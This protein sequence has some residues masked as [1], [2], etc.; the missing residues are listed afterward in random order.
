MLTGNAPST[1]TRVISR[2]P[3][4]A[5]G[6]SQG[7]EIRA[8]D[9]FRISKL[10]GVEP[11][12][13]MSYLAVNLEITNLFKDRPFQIPTIKSHF[14]LTV[15]DI[16]SCPASM[17]TWLA[18]T[19]LTVPGDFSVEIPKGESKAGV[20][21]FLV[22]EAEP[23]A[24][25][26]SFYDTAYGHILLPL[27]GSPKGV[28]IPIEQLPTTAPAKLS[29]T[30]TITITGCSDVTRM[31]S[32]PAP[33]GMVY[34]VVEGQIASNVQALLDLNPGERLFLDI[35][36]GSGTF[37]LP[38]SPITDT[39]PMG[40]LSPKMLAPGS[41]NTFRWVFEVPEPLKDAKAEIYGDISGGAIR[42]PVKDGQTYP[43]AQ[44]LGTYEG[45]WISLT[46]NEM[47]LMS[48]NAYSE[49]ARS[50][51]TTAEQKAE[52]ERLAE[53]E[54]AAREERGEE[55]K[56]EPPPAL[57]TVN[58]DGRFYVVAD[59]T[60]SDKPDGYGT[61]DIRSTV[62]FVSGGVPLGKTAYDP[63]ENPSAGLGGFTSQSL[64]TGPDG[65]TDQLALG[66][67]SAFAV[68]DG[69]SRRGLM[70]FALEGTD[71][72]LSSHY[73][74]DLRL[75]LPTSNYTGAALMRPKARPESE[76]NAFA[77]ALDSEIRRVVEAW[78]A[79]HPKEAAAAQTAVSAPFA[80]TFA[81]GT[82]EIA[83]PSSALY[84][85]EKLGESRTLE[86]VLAQLRNLAWRPSYLDQDRWVTRYAPEAVL[87][88][89]WGTEF[90]LAITAEQLLARAGANPQRSLVVLTEEGR[91]ALRDYIKYEPPE[92]VSNQELPFANLNYLPALYY[93]DSDGKGQVMVVPFMKELRA[94]E[95]YA[96]LNSSGA[97]VPG[98]EYPEA[99]VK[100]VVEA[101]PIS[102]R[103]K[104]SGGGLGLG[105]GLFGSFGEA[106]S[107]EEEAPREAEPQEITVLEESFRLTELS[108]AAVDVGF[109][110]AD[111]RAWLAWIDTPTGRKPGSRAL[112]KEDYQPLRIIYTVASGN[113]AYTHE[114]NLAQGETPDGVFCTLGVNLPELCGE[115]LDSLDK[116]VR[117]YPKDENP[118][119]ISSLRW[120][121]RNS[122][123]RYIAG[124]T[125]VEDSVAKDLGLVIGRSGRT[126]C[127]AVTSQRKPKSEQLVTDI[128]LMGAFN[129]LHNGAVDA[130][131]AFNI[132]SGLGV[133]RL[134][135]KALGK[136]A[137]DYSVIW[138]KRPKG[139]Q[140]LLLTG[141]TLDENI[142][143]LRKAGF[144]EILL[145]RMEKGRAE[146][147]DD[148]MYM[149]ADQPTK[150]GG[151]NRWAMLEIDCRTFETIS[152]LDTGGNNGFVEYLL[153]NH[154]GVD[155]VSTYLGY[156]AGFMMGASTG[157]GAMCAA[158]LIESD[159]DK[160]VALA[161]A[162]A[163]EANEGVKN[164]FT[165]TSF[166]FVNSPGGVASGFEDGLNYYFANASK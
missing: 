155:P 140:L 19:P 12:R 163:G 158:S 25:Q 138:D 55:P 20:L 43:A 44:G 80:L 65:M 132:L 150:L 24:L 126:R 114:V 34:R 109:A 30:F 28:D 69:E 90:D 41:A 86:E 161:K 4:K 77:E 139:S 49:L 52:E 152:V 35:A 110:L 105:G 137:V 121:H 95:G 117:D 32:R 75:P 116:T 133:S 46:V 160:V 113:E 3:L 157:L 154:M 7:I 67:D 60:V 71:H 149:I 27:M 59:I 58:T 118:D 151:Q 15:N 1:D 78:R 88:Q 73:F 141:D 164:Y 57:D 39:V 89:G 47:G 17:C 107:G 123:Y 119:D 84:G 72:F 74:P 54:R 93:R 99:S 104:N 130:R 79:A 165:A 62:G 26:L 8:T 101:I 70:V 76:D 159:Y 102:E 51:R 134:E 5:S 120:Y 94:L 145:R 166:S 92:E 111:E 135:G 50:F 87:T 66:V 131:S 144:P 29:D 103:A 14:Y 53:E 18:E 11:P 127:I 21:V 112:E 146:R 33:A 122:L 85:R 97:G 23:K 82:T 106:I 81:P 68:H 64:L 16:E 9:L 2:T 42:I 13:G 125:A 45:E 91:Q 108:I 129:Q 36:T 96:Y 100:V 128:D 63:R 147:Y 61:G 162:Y 124:Q 22:D 31:G 156:G 142:P 83:P 40:Y 10:R 37:R 6:K 38:I 48:E 136:D 148:I 153:M 143:I 98:T 115:G 56:E